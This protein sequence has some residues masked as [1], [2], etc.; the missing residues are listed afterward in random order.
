MRALF[1]VGHSSRP[2][3]ELIAMCQAHEIA[4]VADVRRFPA[5]RH[6][7]QF[8]RETLMRTLAV[9]G[10]EYDWHPE[11]G[12]R[13]SRP[14]GASPTAWR[15]PAFAAYADYMLTPEFRRAIEPLM[16]QAERE[17]IA[18]MCAEAVPYQC[19][20]RLIADWVVLHGLPV[21]HVLDPHRSEPHRVT[22]LARLDGDDV[23]YDRGTQ[24][25]LAGIDAR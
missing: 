19:H 12:G 23:R 10:I 13:R 1:T 18:I 16:A 7:P 21:V 22:E 6:N 5:S 14:K 9:V 4:R 25:E 24:L 17:S 2:V 15:V 11:L 20:R 3:D 8:G